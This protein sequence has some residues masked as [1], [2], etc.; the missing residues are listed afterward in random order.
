VR[1]E[2]LEPVDRRLAVVETVDLGMTPLRERSL[3]RGSWRLRIKHPARAGVLYPVCVGRAEHWTGVPPGETEPL[4]VHLPRPETLAPDDRYVPG[5]FFTSG[6]DP[7]AL[8]GLGARRIW[9]DPFVIKRDPVTNAEYLAFVN[10]LVAA[11]RLEDAEARVPIYAEENHRA[12][13]RGADGRYVLGTAFQ[14]FRWV[15]AWPVVLVSWHDAV[16][17]A[18]WRGAREGR[19]W[20]LPHDQEWEKAARG[21]DGRAFPFGDFLDP[22]WACMV[23]SHAV[24]PWWRAVEADPIDLSPYGVRGM[25]GNVRDWCFNGYERQGPEAG[26]RVVVEAPDAGAPYRMVRGGSWIGQPEACRAATRLA[27]P[28]DTRLTRRGFRLVAPYHLQ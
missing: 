28:P 14:G 13:T 22:T 25:A 11:G 15:P 24:A 26:A 1:A 17:F 5:G 16:A 21:T 9:I 18:R 3:P 2:R 23:Q 8:D 20:R 10:D 6:G 4:P 7:R 27:S 19:R 12:F